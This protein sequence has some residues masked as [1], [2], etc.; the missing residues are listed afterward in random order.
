[1]LTPMG[2]GNV[3]G[4][5]HIDGRWLTIQVSHD[6]AR[7]IAMKLNP[8]QQMTLKTGMRSTVVVLEVKLR[9]SGRKV[10]IADELGR[11]SWV[12]ASQ[13]EPPLEWVD[14]PDAS[15]HG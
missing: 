14:P 9:P 4:C 3:N 2:R 7:S 12:P 6:V 15:A 8:G 13:L 11:Q 1:M 5:S 10:L